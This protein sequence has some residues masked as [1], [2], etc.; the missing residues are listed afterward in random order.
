MAWARR[1]FTLIIFAVAHDHDRFAHGMIGTILQEFLFAR[2]IDGVVERGASAILQLVH[3]GG[4]QRD[5]VGKVL[6]HLTLGVEAHN[7][8]LVEAGANRVLQEVDGG[9]LLEI[10][11]AVHR[12]ADVDEQ[13][14]VQRQIDLAA[15]VENRLRR[16]VIVENGEIGLAEVADKFAV[17]V[18]GDE[19]NINFIHP[20]VNGEQRA[21]LGIVVRNGSR[22]TD[23]GRSAG[24]RL[25][26][27]RGCAGQGQSRKQRRDQPIMEERVLHAQTVQFLHTYPWP[28]GYSFL[29]DAR[30][31]PKSAS[32]IIFID[33]RG[34]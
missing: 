4:E 33:F 3:A 13:A 18:G 20:F 12:S 34:A 9:I 30:R 29:L 19:Q 21:G 1:D 10:K 31:G 15:E 27:S 26:E 14:E 28:E 5:V 25:G 23:R 8:S 22:G 32:V 24:I 6:G 7:E 11:T 2:A 16:L 17:L